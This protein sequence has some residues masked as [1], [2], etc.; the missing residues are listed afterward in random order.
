MQVALFTTGVANLFFLG[1][2]H[3]YFTNTVYKVAASIP[4]VLTTLIVI[5]ASITIDAFMY[6]GARE[7][8]SLKWGRMP[9]RSQYALFLL[10]VAFT[11]VAFRL[12]DVLSRAADRAATKTET[13]LDDQLVPLLRKTLKVFLAVLVAVRL[14]DPLGTLGAFLLDGPI[15]YALM[16]AVVLITAATGLAYLR[17]EYQEPTPPPV[18]G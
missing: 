6:R 1:V 13:R 7:V 11:W 14:P 9:D 18:D 8:G 5:V 3:G 16:I 10:A 17:M 12:L 4:Q 2:Y 15:L